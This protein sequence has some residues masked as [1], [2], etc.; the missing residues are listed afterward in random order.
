MWN[1]QYAGIDREAIWATL[2]THFQQAVGDLFV[3]MS[4]KHI[5]PPQLS[6]DA[7]PA[8]FLIQLREER[9]GGGR[10]TPN[11]LTLH[12]FIILYVPAPAIDEVPGQE[13]QLAATVL[14]IA[15]KA[16]DDAL[17]PDDARTGKFTL[18]GLVQ[19]CGIAGQVDQDP[20]IQSTQAAAILP[21]Q[22]LVP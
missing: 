9:G 6:Q 12:G 3:T 15:Y 1:D 5:Q 7:Q 16:I 4:R 11:T 2:F 14:N 21:I 19:Y 10:G 18:G 22:I 13:T 17:I 20:G 8:F